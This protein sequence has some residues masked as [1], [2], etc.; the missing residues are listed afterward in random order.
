[1]K[2][3]SIHA[4]TFTTTTTT[5]THAH[6]HIQHGSQEKVLGDMEEVVCATL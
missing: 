1:M 3:P 5:T 6:I 4:V 2:G